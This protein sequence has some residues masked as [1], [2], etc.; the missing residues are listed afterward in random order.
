[1]ITRLSPKKKN[2]RRAKRSFWLL[3]GCFMHLENIQ[4]TSNVHLLGFTTAPHTQRKIL[5]H[6]I[7]QYILKIKRKNK[8]NLKEYDGMECMHLIEII[9]GIV[10]NVF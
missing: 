10:E 4:F 9:S 3:G 5:L 2:A 1:M 6:N 8:S 7:V